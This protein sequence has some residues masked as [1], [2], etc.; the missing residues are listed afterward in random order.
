MNSFRE[1]IGRGGGSVA[2]GPQMP[3]KRPRGKAADSGLGSVTIARD[4]TRASDHRDGD[5][6]RL[7][8]ESATLKVGTKTIPVELVNL[9]GGGAMIATGEP[10]EMWQ[11]VVLVLGGEHELECAVRWLRGERVGLEF[12]HETQVVGDCATRDAMLLQT[13]RRSFP[14]AN[15]AP[16][17]SAPAKAPAPE[18]ARDE[19]RRGSPRHPLIWSG[20]IIHEF[21]SCRVRLRNISET[22]ALVQGAG[23]YP[24]DAEVLLDLGEAG[25]HFA[26]VSWSHGDQLGLR[27]NQP[28]DISQLGKAKPDVANHR[29][30]QPEYL[31]ATAAEKSAWARDWGASSIDELAVELEGFLKR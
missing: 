13:I 10:L 7:S 21:D 5:R 23:A 28:F 24:A 17:R 11:K 16:V 19:H 14:A 29:W 22:G 2:H 18:P 26:R 6:H 25:Q 30:S 12:A 3:A 31:R 1:A 27:F 9:S 8:A 4:S 20:D 15:K